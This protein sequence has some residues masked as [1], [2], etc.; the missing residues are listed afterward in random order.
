[1]GCGHGFSL[2]VCQDG[3]VTPQNPSAQ[4]SIDAPLDVVWRI[5]LDTASYGDW[6][7]FVIA[8][9]CP[10][11]P[12]PGD[13]IRLTVRWPN[14]KTATSPE[15][16]SLVEGPSIDAE[17]VTRATLAYV[18]RGLPARIGLV[19]GT[20]YQRLAQAPGGPTTYD[21]VEEFSG[22]LVRFAGPARVAEGFARHAASLKQRAERTAPLP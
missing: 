2:W 15:Q 10:S 8:A 6:N 14:G 16:I 18:Y 20:R 5:M 9:E 7:P 4:A 11:P 1:M 19:R 21:T 22:P 3:F 13:P 12:S 17:G